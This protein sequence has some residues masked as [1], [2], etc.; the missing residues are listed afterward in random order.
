MLKPFLEDLHCRKLGPSDWKKEILV[1][2]IGQS[3]EGGLI[4]TA[5]D[6][7]VRAILAQKLE[8][9]NVKLEQHLVAEKGLLTFDELSKLKEPIFLTKDP[10]VNEERSKGQKIIFKSLKKSYVTCNKNLILQ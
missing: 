3:H 2:S 8:K 4:G 7:V 1:P 10:T 9:K 6:Y 5:F